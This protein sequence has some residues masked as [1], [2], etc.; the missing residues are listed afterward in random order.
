MDSKVRRR[1]KDRRNHLMNG[2]KDFN[3]LK[4]KSNKSM[5]S[6][7]KSF[8]KLIF[9]CLSIILIIVSIVLILSPFVFRHS[10]TVRRLLVFMNYVNLPLFKDLSDP[11]NSF[12]MN[13]TKNIYVTHED[14][15]QMIRLGV[16]HLLPSSRSQDCL[17]FNNSLDSSLD[18]SDDRPIFLY[19][20]GNGGAR[21]GHHRRQ[22]YEVLSK[23]SQLDGHVV[24]FDYR[25]YGD[26]SNVWPTA[27]GLR[28]DTNAVYRWLLDQKHVNRSRVIVYAH[29]LGT[30][31]GIRFVSQLAEEDNPRAM[32]LEAPFTSMRDALQ[33]HPFS[34][35]FRNYFPFFDTYF[36]E[37]I[38]SNSVT[39]FDSISLLN[40]IGI[41]L[42]I[43]HSQDDGIIPF[44]LGHK[45]YEQSLKDQPK[46]CRKA[47][48][49]AFNKD[50]GYGHKYIFRD[51][52]LPVIIENFIK[53]ND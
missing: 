3:R 43:L 32:I 30:A 48:M 7:I 20:H 25:G 49:I 45:L 40:K 51:S 24:T 29:S 12:A 35:I 53:T 23:S 5:L 34:K 6:R 4:V 19:L 50:Y 37:P 11:Q 42:L 41:P 27:D 18:F 36:V 33:W 52:Q 46:N 28:S 14:N 47:Q 17:K 39:N 8:L 38:V 22:L 10:L 16:W 31:V 2:R 9:K 13:C 44:H 26:S 21:G 1:T 15:N